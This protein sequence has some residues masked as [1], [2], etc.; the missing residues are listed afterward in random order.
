M[1]PA[2]TITGVTKKYDKKT[3]ALSNINL[4]VHEGEFLVLVGPSGCGKSTLLRIMSGIDRDYSG[5]VAFHDGITRSDMGFVFQS[6]ALLPWLTIEDNISIGLVARGMPL[7][8]RK[9]IVD[10]ELKTFGLEKFAKHYPRELSG[11]MRQRVGIA[12][13]LATNPKIIFL[14]EPFSELDSFTAE[15]LRQELLS[16]WAE[17]KPTIVM[18][19]HIVEEALELADRVIGL[20]PRPGKIEAT[21]PVTLARPRQKRSEPFFA[22]TD[23]LYELI[24]P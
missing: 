24:K 8:Q 18:V 4:S 20:T 10:R 14:D 7:A 3:L 16:I 23:Q 5:S 9:K 15:E 21:V 12:R 6:F 19:T 22:L 1:K 2:I 13:A 11:G 17:R